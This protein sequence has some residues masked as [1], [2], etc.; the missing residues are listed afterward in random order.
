MLITRLA[1][2]SEQVNVDAN[3]EV[4]GLVRSNSFSAW[5]YTYSQL[6]TLRIEF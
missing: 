2:L 6:D 3:D 5:C 1:T 4:L